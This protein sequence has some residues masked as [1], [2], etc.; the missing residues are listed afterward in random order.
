MSDIGQHFTTFQDGSILTGRTLENDPAGIYGFNLNSI[1]I[2][3]LGNFDKDRD[4]MSQ[5]QK[6]TI[7]R[8]TAALCLKFSISVNSDR[9]VYH[10]WF[11][12]ISGKRNKGWPGSSKD[13]PGTN[14]FGG[15]TVKDCEENF[16]PLVSQAK[17]NL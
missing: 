8:L 17:A 14:F 3:N 11:D 12:K 16:L 10:Y 6:N 5:S 4:V 15:N 13:C 9:L 2:E 7:V 1:C